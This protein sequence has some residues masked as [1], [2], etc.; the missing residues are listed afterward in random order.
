M[1]VVLL[2]FVIAAATVLQTSL[3]PHLAI[4]GFRADLLLLV[5]VAFAFRDGPLTGVYLGFVAGLVADL[6]VAEAPVGLHA[7]VFATVGYGVGSVRPYLATE[8]AS[9]PLALALT[10]GLVATGGYALLAG[11]FGSTRYTPV[12]V[13]RT[14]IVVALYDT[15]LA[16][17]V[18]GVAS[19]ISDRVPAERAV[20][21]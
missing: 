12:F 8:S 1:R 16:P 2:T 10:T 4:A 14:A 6:L 9:A 17:I 7:L 15:L 5:T 19:A 11:A 18:F 20:P 13:V 3:L 21:R